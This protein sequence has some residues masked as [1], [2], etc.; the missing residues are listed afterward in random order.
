MGSKGELSL[1]MELFDQ[2]LEIAPNDPGILSGA[3]M[4]RAR[5]WNYDQTASTPETATKARALATR[6]L[7]LAPQLGEPWLALATLENI[8]SR[9]RE[10][11]RSLR[12]ALSNTPGLVRGHD[13]L[14]SIL[15]EVVGLDAG[16]A[17]FEQALS[18]DPMWWGAR[19]GL[20]R[21]HALRGDWERVESLLDVTYDNTADRTFHAITAA[22]LAL[23]RGAGPFPGEAPS[24]IPGVGPAIAAYSRAREGHRDI[25][26]TVFE[27]I[28][29][30]SRLRTRL[31]PIVCQQFAEIAAHIGERERAL[32]A[33]EIGAEAMLYDLPW[34]D[35]CPALA[36][37]RD[38]SR[39]QSVREIVA[40]RGREVLSA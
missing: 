34:L 14:G 19:L 9:W 7:D 39:F 17:S 40:A 26:L 28:M 16:I 38:D 3:A 13:M 12:T 37:I 1:A 32:R 27:E 18:L 20:A 29:L 24:D 31:R 36:P 11:L 22:R 25:D 2:A 21:A 35:L 15:V 8:E 4:A 33:V 6:A 30:N 5:L 10:C 23:W